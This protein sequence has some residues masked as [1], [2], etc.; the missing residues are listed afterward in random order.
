M[1]DSTEEEKHI[2]V[3]SCTFTIVGIRFYNGVAHEGEFVRLVREPNNPYDRS[4]V[5]VD[6]MNS[7]KVGHIKREQAAIIAGLMDNAN[8]HLNIEGTIPS[9]GNAYTMPVRVD[10]YEV[11]SSM[12]ISSVQCDM[13]KVLNNAFH[14]RYGFRLS[15]A[16]GR[17][18]STADANTSSSNSS[19]VMETTIM[20]WQTQQEQLDKMF[21]KQ[22]SEKLK[23]L[24]PLPKKLPFSPNLVLYDYQ[25][26]GIRWLIHQE[27]TCTGRLPP[28]YQKKIE[29]GKTVYFCDITNSAQPNLPK[30]AKGSILADEMGLGKTIQTIGLL[31]GNPS[32]HRRVLAAPTDVG[33]LV[34]PLPPRN[35]ILA[36]KVKDLKMILK[37]VGLKISGTKNVLAERCL[38]GMEK[39]KIEGNHFPSH[40]FPKPTVCVNTTDGKNRVCTLIVS[41]VT[42]MTNWQQQI[43]QHVQPNILRIG[44]YQ[45]SNRS[46]LLPEIIKGYYDV[47]LV[48]YQTLSSEFTKR[49]DNVE[50]VQ[51]KS[52]QESIFDVPFFRI[53][54]DEAH[55]IRSS[56]T[57]AFKAVNAV[58]AS[59]KLALTGTPFVNRADDI[60]SLLKFC[61]VEPL[62]EKVIFRRAITNEIQNGNEVGLTRLR[63]TMSHILLRR[64][65]ALVQIKLVSKEIQL[66]SITFPEG[67]HKDVYKALFG[68]FRAVY[69]ALLSD[70]K[71]NDMKNYNH[72]FEKL[73]RMRQ[74]CCS[75]LLVPEER[76]TAA[77]KLWEQLQKR[78]ADN[79]N[80][81]TA[82]EG[83]TL[84]EK[85]KGTFTTEK[86]EDS[87]LPECAICLMEME[88]N[89]AVILKNCTH[90]FC[91]GCISRVF[92]GASPGCK[93]FCPLC[94]QPFENSDMI[95]RSIATA[96]IACHDELTESKNSRMET[97]KSGIEMSP[98]IAT[99]LEAMKDMPIDEKGVIF[100]QFTSFLNLIGAA[101]KQAG[102]LFTRIDGSMATS[103][104][105]EA[106]RAFCSNDDDSPRFILCSLHAAGTGINLTR[107]NHAFMMDCWWNVAIENQAMDRI[108]RIGQTR[109]VRVIRFVMKDTI[110]ERMVIL[111][112]QKSLQGKAS[113]EK[114]NPDEQ[115][116]TR[117]S[118]LQGLLMLDDDSNSE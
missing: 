81:L 20:N 43:E 104:R 12:M 63:T 47:M 74:A 52:K 35:Q 84:L 2:H 49:Y 67:F 72:I 69:V 42:V 5:R 86:D 79:Q 118:N 77:I 32:P 94:R 91:H 16:S 71:Q 80:P 44:I 21:D 34:A 48:S 40:F 76:R 108:H 106:I 29:R 51:K 66:R 85:L 38:Q 114:L 61:E 26:L 78:N 88:M 90:I 15:S 39:G 7:E 6:N 18:F 92:S 28:F 50:G 96:S 110:E 46:D 111:Q 37:N 31:L 36:A 19:I 64:S 33:T 27:T 103:C 116:R 95:Q 14:K 83:K 1:E 68:T 8:L 73:M 10:F 97:E 23:D 58:D 24:P 70:G 65:K 105:T 82:E 22:V 93:A 17:R 30:Q 100:S 89:E 3:A 102:H 113:V 75:A 13:T 59:Y 56:R 101:I 9:S 99:L 87:L 11:L 60:F 109:K 57:K 98:K 115:R 117:M 53:V 41:P 107:G 112:E 45:G 62:S 55:N 25:E 4:A 54:L